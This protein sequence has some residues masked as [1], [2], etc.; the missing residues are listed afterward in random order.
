MPLTLLHHPF[1][2][3]DSLFEN[4]WDGFRCLSW[5]RGE[6]VLLKSKNLKDISRSYPELQ[7]L[8]HW[9]RGEDLI[10][11]G[12]LC[13]LDKRGHPDFL[14]MQH[15]I[16]LKNPDSIDK[17]VREEPITYIVWDLL[18]LHGEDLRPRPLIERRKLLEEVVLENSSLILSSSVT[19][20]GIDLFEA[21]KEEGLEGIV[22][23]KK[24]SPYLSCTNEYWFKVKCFRYLEATIG[25]FTK[26]GSF[27]I[28]IPIEGD[29]KYLGSLS[30]KLKE[31]DLL[32]LYREL[33]DRKIERSPFYPPLMKKEIT[34]VEPV[35]NCRV[36]YLEFTKNQRLRHALIL[37]I[38]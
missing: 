7:S 3:S 21:V 14:R 35:I 37:S 16:S 34:W 10:L 28:G 5:V 4:K 1:D 13:I 38:V 8:P 36:R 26:R 24:E 32:S 19:E 6:R 30:S 2:D 20:K 18:S 29:L 9:L 31:E 17:R 25:G 23:K 33:E 27:L 12:E 15:S 22:A 11:D